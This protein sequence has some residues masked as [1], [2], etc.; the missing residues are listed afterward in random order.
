V[1]DAEARAG[2]LAHIDALRAKGHRVFQPANGNAQATAQG[3]FVPPTLIEIG[4]IGELE[5]EVFGPVLHLVRYAR[6]DLPLLLLQI[7]ATGYGLTL[8]V[9]TRIDETIA[10]VVDQAHA[11]NIYVNRN[12][13]GA[14]VGVQPFGG[15]GLSGTGPKAGGPMYLLRM[16]SRYPATALASTLA[17]AD[18]LRPRDDTQRRPLLATLQVL[19]D[20]ARSQ[21]NMALVQTCQRLAATTPS[22]VLRTLPGPTGENNSYQILPRERVLCLAT[23]EADLLT[24][25][26][27]VLATGGQALW[28]V[29]H[30][31]LHAR[32]PAALQ[33]RVAL[34]AQWQA[35]GVWLDAVL[36]HGDSDALR[37]AC[38]AIATRSGPIVG[39][40]GLP[41]GS[42][43]VPLER[44][45]LERSLSVNTAAAGGNASLMTIG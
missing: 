24:Q 33:E 17:P 34:V 19:E 8:G 38:R 40:T 7:N 14:V 30:S 29:Q 21:Q 4:S 13:V 22:G 3:T 9:H 26:A 2:I 23:Q 36:H 18:A 42:T 27:S 11:G 28:P 20:W 32:L 1:I 35:D 6:K 44:L 16:L 39:V 5:R 45:V 37:T 10:Q 25:L 15:E 31:A 12:M 43:E 41:S